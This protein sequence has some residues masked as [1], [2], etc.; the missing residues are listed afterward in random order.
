MRES[1]VLVSQLEKLRDEY[2]KGRY[3]RVLARAKK[4]IDRNPGCVPALIY[5]SRAAQLVQEKEIKGDPKNVYRLSKQVL[6]DAIEIDPHAVE[7]HIDL[8]Y[9]LYSYENSRSANA[10]FDAAIKIASAQLKE[11]YV[12]KIK[13]LGELGRNDERKATYADAV[14]VFGKAR[15]LKIALD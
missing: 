10:R 1:S 12:G 11:A 13:C 9:Y 3:D 15:D 5:Y 7:A 2:R 4:V 14:A 8:A 6:L